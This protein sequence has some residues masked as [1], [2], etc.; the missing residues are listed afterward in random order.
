MRNGW[1][2]GGGPVTVSS[3]CWGA[4]TRPPAASSAWPPSPMT[5]PWT[6]GSGCP[7]AWLSVTA[8]IWSSGL[9]SSPTGMSGS[10][11]HWGPMRS[12]RSAA[13]GL[14]RRRRGRPHLGQAVS[15]R[16]KRDRIGWRVFV[17]VDVTAAP[18]VTDRRRG[19]VGVDLNADHLAVTETDSSGNWLRSWRVPLVTYGRSSH[20]AL[21]LIGDAVAGVVEYARA[22]GK[23]IVIEKLDFRQKRAS[24]EGESRKYSRMLSSFSYGKIKAYFLSR[25]GRQGVEIYQV[26]PAYSSLVG[27][28]KFM[29]RYGLSVHQAAA[30]VLARRLPWLLGAHPAPAGLSAG[31]WRP[32]RLHGTREETREARLDVLGCDLWAAGTGA[33]SAAPAG[34]REP[35]PGSG[36]PSGRPEWGP[37]RCSRVRFPGGAALYC[38]GG[39]SHSLGNGSGRLLPLTTFS[40]TVA[41]LV[42]HARYPLARGGQPSRLDTPS[43]RVPI[44]AR[45]GR[46]ASPGPPAGPASVS[47]R[48]WLL[49][50]RRRAVPPGS[51]AGLPAPAAGI[52]T[53][54]GPTPRSRPVRLRA[55]ASPGRRRPSAASARRAGIAGGPCRFRPTA[56]PP[57]WRRSRWPS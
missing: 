39:R 37:F 49:G 34:H 25:G 41:D 33:C 13:A 42:G 50:A 57:G 48:H 51:A 27:R 8:S 21:A 3:S 22:V 15:Y 16:F 4:G 24:L 19:A 10:W 11:L 55:P 20:Q 14:G 18:V 36:C 32:G 23:P 31:Q 38:W 43:S 9:C 6:C 44:P 12:L 54:R 7:T 5:V 47:F 26:N 40:T 53:G 45:P 1:P 52:P 17:T 56:M 2:T 35:N 28:V 29:E 46:P 30:L